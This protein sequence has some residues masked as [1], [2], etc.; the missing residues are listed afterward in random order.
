MDKKLP[1]RIDT[2]TLQIGIQGGPGS[3]N[4][5]AIRQY[6]QK[7]S[8]TKFQIHYLYRTD[9]V[10]S[11]LLRGEIDFGQ[12][13]VK[14]SIGGIVEETQA[15]LLSFPNSVTTI[16][17]YSL[18][19]RHVL[20]IHPNASPTDITTIMTH[21]Q[22]LKQCQQTL[23]NRYPTIEQRSGE[24]E[25]LDSAKVAADLKNG[26]IP[27]NVAALGCAEMAVQFGLKVIDE[28]LQDNDNNTTTFRLVSRLIHG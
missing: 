26:S 4:E 1:Q 23:K 7:Q 28:N 13:A 25:Q 8:S 9:A 6:L 19:V 15:A 5:Q 12:F 27:D 24:G 14:N 10:L 18:S 3:F 21:P 16:E 11:T 22:V 2:A 20:M 17:E